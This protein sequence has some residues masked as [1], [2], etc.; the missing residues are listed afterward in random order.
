MQ[1]RHAESLVGFLR[2]G[3]AALQG[4]SDVVRVDRRTVPLV[5]GRGLVS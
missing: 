2:V 3:L 4:F 5:T 1:H